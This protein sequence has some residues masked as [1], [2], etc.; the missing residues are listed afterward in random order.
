MTETAIDSGAASDLGEEFFYEHSGRGGLIVPGALLVGMP[1]AFILA[2]V[3]SYIVVYCPVVGYPN[4]LFLGG[5]IFGVGFTIGQIAEFTK[6]RSPFL[7]GVMGLLAGVATLYFAWGF[8]IKALVQYSGQA[9]PLPIF[10]AL[11]D[12]AWM[13]HTIV[14]INE[15]GWWK[16][17]GIA[18]W[19]LSIIEAGAIL[20][21][22]PFLAF[23]GIDREVFCEDCGKW[24][25]PTEKR[26]LKA[27]D[28]LTEP[29]SHIAILKLEEC[30]TKDYPRYTAEV[31]ACPACEGMTAI[32]IQSVTVKIEDG[33]QK[34][35]TA[36]VPGILVRKT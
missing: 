33:E 12:P 35:E 18:Q 25:K 7:C 32:R 16:P 29:L 23:V 21:G 5:L 27:P 28:D 19:I 3:Y 8:F 20:I 30:T 6:C 1:V 22:I 9:P 31:L 17:S 34:E 13:W 26:H 2:A 4:I 15:E 36:D 24:C 11:A 10:D 14:G